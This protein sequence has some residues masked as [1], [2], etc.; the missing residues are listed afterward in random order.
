MKKRITFYCFVFALIVLDGV[1]LRSPNLL[2]KIGLIVYKYSYLRTFPKA[3]LTVTIV[4]GMAVVLSEV[5]RFLVARG[6]VKKS[7][8]RI[9]ML[10]FLIIS[11]A[12]LVKTGL[13]FQAWS[14]AHT[15][16]RFRYGAYLLPLIWIVVFGYHLFT[17]PSPIVMEEPAGPQV[18]KSET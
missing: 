15:G 1:L 13:D 6:S 8:G 9:I 7:S 12:M 11:I 5:I 10:I 3:L 18:G 4:V 16:V 17:L 2:G 14:Y